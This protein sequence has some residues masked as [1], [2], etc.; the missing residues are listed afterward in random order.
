VFL[1]IA[2]LSALAL[3]LHSAGAAFDGL[4]AGLAALPQSPPMEP[5]APPPVVECEP[6]PTAIAGETYARFFA[7]T[8]AAI[9]GPD[10]HEIGGGHVFD[11]DHWAP[12]AV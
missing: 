5:P 2:F 1:I 12:Q 11:G 8:G 6:P 7:R 9:V 4:A 10:G 3:A